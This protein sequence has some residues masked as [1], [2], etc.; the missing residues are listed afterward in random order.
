M[1]VLKRLSYKIY[2]I[3]AY[4]PDFAPIEMCFSLLKINLSKLNKNE[5]VKLSF[6]HNFWKIHNSLSNLTTTLCPIQFDFVP[7]H[8]DF[9]PYVLTL[10]I[11]LIFSKHHKI[12]IW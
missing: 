8:F 11:H 3:P 1:I 9:V 12:K 2:Y 10:S 6:K 7:S 4:S 5:N